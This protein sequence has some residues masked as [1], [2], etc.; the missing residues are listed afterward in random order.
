MA[1]KETLEIL[2]KQFEA[3]ATASRGLHHLMVEVGN[4]ERDRMRG[5]EWF[6]RESGRGASDPGQ[7][8]RADPWH[9]VRSAGLPWVH[10][11]FREVRPGEELVAIPEDRIVRD[12]SGTPRAIFE[13][14]RLRSSFLCGDWTAVR[15]F[16]SLAEATSQTLT[17]APGLADHELAVDLTDLFQAPRGGIRYVFGEVPNP[18]K[19]FIAS[20][21]QAGQLIYEHGVLIDV[22][23][24]ESLPGVDHWLLLLHRLS[25]RRIPGSPLQGQ[26]LAWHGNT[27]TPLEWVV[28]QEFDPGWPEPWR[29][30]FSQI[31]TSSYYSVL[32]SREH[33]LD[34]NSASALAVDILLTTRTE[35]KPV[36]TP[37]QGNKRDY[38]REP[39]YTRP[40]PPVGHGV[41][42]DLKKR[43][44]P[45]I[46]LLTAT[47]T[48]R[49]T[50]LK[51]LD[52]APGE[53]QVLLAPHGNNTYFVGR[54]GKY[55]VALCMC[56]MGASGR[57]SAQIV[58]GEVIRFWKPAA[59]I[60]VGIAFGKDPERQ[61]IGDVLISE[62]IIAYE[63]ERVG[64]D[65]SVARGH[66][67]VAGARM[68]D[69]FR[70]F[71]LGWEFRDPTGDPCSIRTGPILSGEKLVDN[72]NFKTLLFEKHPYAIGGEMEGVGLS[73]AA[74]REKCEW[75]LVKAI[76][77]WADGEKSDNHQAFA[78]A[79]AV[80]LVRHVLSQPGVIS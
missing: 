31:P 14:M 79:S 17:D 23:I 35:A 40:L 18:P 30:R 26:R 15:G 4:D 66:H 22:P 28:E 75:I 12:G 61:R 63:P 45:K 29:E 5:P 38:S 48:E 80:S 6:V 13:P 37:S 42:L 11:Q 54:L 44:K 36:A 9:T 56:A 73:A 57:D 39:W 25:W 69:R 19:H 60:M 62:R 76:C 46:M 7:L 70:N 74:E 10:P 43:V 55:P 21:W 2:R 53:A 8:I 72:P 3:R 1:W 27:T 32:G 16:K 51:Q 77:D 71:T 49:D 68:F 52:P 34:V 20:G 33:P 67:F 47:T 64:V 59:V 50:V 78:A 24:S 41:A 58:T 65:A